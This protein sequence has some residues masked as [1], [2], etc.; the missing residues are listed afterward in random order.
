MFNRFNNE[1]KQLNESNNE[2]G[3]NKDSNDVSRI[4][5]GYVAT[6]TALESTR[7]AALKF[8]KP[9]SYSGS[10]KLYDSPKAKVSENLSYLIQGKESSIP[11]LVMCLF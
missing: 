11:I 7:S 6:Q 5:Q 3:D 4:T 2:N 10:R 8:A 1:I 9:D